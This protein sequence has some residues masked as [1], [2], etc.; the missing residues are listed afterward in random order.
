MTPSARQTV[1]VMLVSLL[2][3]VG[4][5]NVFDIGDSVATRL[6]IALALGAALFAGSEFITR[7]MRS[8]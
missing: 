7:V 4:T 3:G 5:V 6:V 2:V 1:G 8:R